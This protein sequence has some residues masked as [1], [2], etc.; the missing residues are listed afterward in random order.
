MRDT[1][2]SSRG[3]R[4]GVIAAAVVLAIFGVVV[5]VV[6]LDGCSMVHGA[7]QQEH[8]G[9]GPHMTPVAIAARVKDAGLPDLALPDCSV[10]GKRVEDGVS[11]RCFAEYMRIDALLGTHGATYAQMPR[12]ATKDGKVPMTPRE[13]SRTPAASRP[14]IRPATSGLPRPP[15]RRR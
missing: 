11:A 15:C 7:L 5:I 12:F 4:L 8:V 3:R 9:G 1:L 6:G 14:A 10:A 2:R 13:L